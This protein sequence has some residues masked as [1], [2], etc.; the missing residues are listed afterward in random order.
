MTDTPVCLPPLYAGDIIG[1]RCVYMWGPF[2]GAYGRF[3]S[4]KDAK[5][6]SVRD[7]NR[8]ATYRAQ[9]IDGEYIVDGMGNIILY[10]EGV[11]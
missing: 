5:V 11:S 6:L 2:D 3:D 4:Y 7:T 8:N 1:K 9:D 10:F